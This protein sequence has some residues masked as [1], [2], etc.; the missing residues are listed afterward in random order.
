MPGV[1]A[2]NFVLYNSLGGG[3]IASLRSDPQVLYEIQLFKQ[4]LYLF[5]FKTGFLAHLSQRLWGELTVYW[6]KPMQTQ[7]E[8]LQHI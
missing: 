1:H 2:L 7:I 8:F 4:V 6:L 3:G 5:N